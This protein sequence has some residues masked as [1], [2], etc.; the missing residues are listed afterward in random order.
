MDCIKSSAAVFKFINYVGLLRRHVFTC[1]AMSLG[2][3]FHIHAVVMDTLYGV[4][5]LIPVSVWLPWR[6]PRLHV[7]WGSSHRWAGISSAF[8]SFM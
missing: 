6:M 5:N 4:E 2:I 1:E 8:K 7:A 3:Q